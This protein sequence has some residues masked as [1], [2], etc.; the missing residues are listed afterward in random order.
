MS[1]PPCCDQWGKSFSRADNLQRHMRN[2]TGRGV[3]TTVAAATTVPAPAV[4][5]RSRL[6]FKLQ[7]TREALEGN[8]QQ[9]TVNMKEAKSLST[10]TKAITVFKPVMTDFQQKHIA[11]KLLSALFSTKRSILL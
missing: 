5:P 10:L 8:V 11:N 3:A 4:E 6:Q 1:Q 9:F 7:K 2:C